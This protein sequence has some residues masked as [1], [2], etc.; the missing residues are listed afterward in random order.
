[1]LVL[2]RRLGEQ[3]VITTPEGRKIEVTVVDIG[4][5]KIRLGVQADKEVTIHRREVQDEYDRMRREGA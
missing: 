5:E 1:M 3:I 2:S 4:R